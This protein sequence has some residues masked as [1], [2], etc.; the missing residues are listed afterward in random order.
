[1]KLVLK[2]AAGIVLGA[3][4]VFVLRLIV[5]GVAV[6]HLNTTAQQ[7]IQHMQQSQAQAM[8]R[9]RQQQA[10]AKQAKLRTQE[11]QDRQAVMAELR[12][13][14]LQERIDEKRRADAVAKAKKDAAFRAWLKLPGW[15]DNPDGM[16]VLARC[17]D[18]KRQER[19][20][21]EQLLAQGAIDGI[22]AD[23]ARPG[24]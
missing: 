13:L 4:G 5:V 17:A 18:I 8:A 9:L 14:E 6:D 16:H 15:C 21:F 12:R 22:R 19:T 1:M 23:R 24:D 3:V 20:R 2:I 11:A 10:D 7:S